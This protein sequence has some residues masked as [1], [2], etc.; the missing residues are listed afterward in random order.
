MQPML[1]A[2]GLHVLGKGEC[3]ATLWAAEGL[4]AS[5]EILM[6][7]EE[8]AVLETLPADVAQVRTA[9]VYVLTAVILHD[10][11][12]FENHATLWAFIGF[13]SSVASLVEAQG[14]AVWESLIALLARKD[15]FLGMGHHV[16]GDRHLKLEFLAAQGA[17]E[18][19]FYCIIAVMVP[20]LTNCREDPLTFC[21]L[22]STLLICLHLL[23]WSQKLLLPLPVLVSVFNEAAA[24]LE[25]KAAFFTGEGREL[26]LVCVKVAVKVERLTAVESL[27]TLFADQTIL[28][29]SS[30]RVG[31]VL[32]VCVL[33]LCVISIISQT[34]G[35]QLL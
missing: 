2:V 24:V 14:H 23:L 32:S 9:A 1:A 25:G 11:V 30:H 28:F 15:A 3:F 21:T 5:V 35:Q 13:E 34:L 26:I 22:K 29:L 27:P 12:V 6:L 33:I 4:L 31:V 7:M 20:Q 17:V 19:L 8:A 10:G 18:R 16:L